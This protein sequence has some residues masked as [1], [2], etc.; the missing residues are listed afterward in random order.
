MLPLVV[1]ELRFEDLFNDLWNRIP[2]VVC[3]ITS[4][5]LNFG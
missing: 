5:V 1:E 3:V 4:W 2:R